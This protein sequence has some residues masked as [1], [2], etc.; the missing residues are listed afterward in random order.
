MLLL[1]KLKGFGDM[2]TA[3]PNLK[4]KKDISRGVRR[5]VKGI[6]PVNQNLFFGFPVFSVGSVRD[7][8]FDFELKVKN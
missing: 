5:E 7:M 6:F 4:N 1:R 8:C 2:K 3:F